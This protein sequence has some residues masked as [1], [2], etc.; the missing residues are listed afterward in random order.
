MRIF[1][2][3]ITTAVGEMNILE[4]IDQEWGDDFLE[5]LRSRPGLS[6]ASPP[7]PVSLTHSDVVE[8]RGNSGSGK[9]LLLS[10]LICKVLTPV[11]EGG[12]GAAVLLLNLDHKIKVSDLHRLLT[13]QGKTDE[14]AKACLSNLFLMSAYDAESY[15]LCIAQLPSVLRKYRNISLVAIDSAGAFFHSERIYRD[16][17]LERFA[18]K[19]IQRVSKVIEKFHVSLVYTVQPFAK[20]VR[21]NDEDPNNDPEERR[22]NASEITHKVSLGN[23][24]EREGAIMEIESEGEEVKFRYVISNFSDIHVSQV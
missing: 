3:D 1:S 9:S 17:F 18:A 20:K 4:S 19:R 22:D 2:D 6:G 11:N 13:S 8:I 7:F 24:Q 12:C 23:Q 14:A 15:N 16:L 10:H 5:R 21:V